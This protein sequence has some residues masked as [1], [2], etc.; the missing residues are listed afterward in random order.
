[1]VSFMPLLLCLQG[2][3]FQY[4]LNGRLRRPLYGS[5]FSEEEKNPFP[6]PEIVLWIIHPAS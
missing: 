2:K 6:L 5:G 4:S 1:M 3:N